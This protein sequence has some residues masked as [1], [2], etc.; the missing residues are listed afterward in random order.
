MDFDAITVDTS[1]LFAENYNLEGGLLARFEQFSRIPDISFVL[2]DV[3]VR[4]MLSHMREKTKE[5]LSAYS[6][7]LRNGLFYRLDDSISIAKIQKI[8][9]TDIKEVVNSRLKEYQTKTGLEIIPLGD[10]DINKVINAYFGRKPPFSDKKKEE[11]PDALAL[12]SLE[13]WAEENNKK[14]LVISKDNDWKSYCRDNIFLYCMNSIEEALSSLYKDSSF[15]L[16]ILKNI[17]SDYDTYERLMNR[18]NEK[19]MNAS[20]VI[21]IS[22]DISSSFEYEEDFFEANFMDVYFPDVEKIEII[23]IDDKNVTISIPAELTY[24]VEGEY[25]FYVKD[26]D[27][28]IK[29][30]D[31]SIKDEMEFKTNLIISIELNE[32]RL[33]NSEIL[34]VDFKDYKF[35]KSIDLDPDFSQD[36]DEP[37]DLELDET[38]RE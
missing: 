3:I 9:E 13:K 38:E 37:I 5:A 4:E 19:I 6:K 23:E 31:N 33:E 36:Y 25:S 35:N 12:V 29:M 22:L 17:F 14:I 27:D 15:V 7:A 34:M 30:G 24:L 21:S 1:I 2:S 8:K 26:E 18:L 32:D 28:Y 16:G 11:F 20:D 10:I